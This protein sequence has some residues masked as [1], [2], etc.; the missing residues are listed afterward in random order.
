MNQAAQTM[1][2]HCGRLFT[3]AE[4][5]RADIAGK[6]PDHAFPWTPVGGRLCPGSGQQ[7][8]NPES[9]RRPLWKENTAR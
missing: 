9:D 3:Y 1:C 2:P 5:G 7:P 4:C 8:R 6:I